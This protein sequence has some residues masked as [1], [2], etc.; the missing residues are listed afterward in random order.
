ML[1]DRAEAA[2]GAA[3][4]HFFEAAGRLDIYETQ[5]RIPLVSALHFVRDG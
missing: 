4:Q 5:R 2:A 1:L 3:V